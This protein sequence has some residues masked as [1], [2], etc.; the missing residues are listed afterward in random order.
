MIIYGRRLGDNMEFKRLT[1]VLCMTLLIIFGSMLG[2]SYAWYAFENA[3]IS[4]FGTTIKE[5]PTVI[6][7]QT[8]FI[9][10]SLNIPIYDEDKENFAN[11][12]AFTITFGENLEKYETAISI[13]LDEIFMDDELKITNYKYELV[14]NNEVISSGDFSNLG[15]E[16]QIVLLP[17]TVMEITSYPNTYTYEL[18]IWLSED[19]TN[20]N[21]LM[22][23]N[24]NGKI[25]INSA[26]K[27][28]NG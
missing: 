14:Q 6:F 26:V 21:Y 23:K 28:R 24:F 20:Q 5:A 10:S 19:G 11:V 22:N 9:S 7:S 3:E 13:V 4:I 12:N 25:K 16:Q 18:Y 17:S 2:T 27:R 1:L 8:E 15:I